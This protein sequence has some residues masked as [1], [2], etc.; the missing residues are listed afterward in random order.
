MN[1]DDKN[2]KTVVM[3]IQEEIDTIVI[4][5]FRCGLEQ[6]NGYMK[7]EELLHRIE[8]FKNTKGYKAITDKNANLIAIK[9][10]EARINEHNNFKQFVTSEGRLHSEILKYSDDRIKILES[11]CSNVRSVKEV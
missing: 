8:M 3:N 11:E 1:T 7:D 4:A 9:K 5:A 10:L 2:N 6:F